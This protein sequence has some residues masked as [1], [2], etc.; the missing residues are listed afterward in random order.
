MGYIDLEEILGDPYLTTL[1]VISAAFAFQC[2]VTACAVAVW[3]WQKWG[4]YGLIVAYGIQAVLMLAAGS[5]LAVGGSIIGL[6]ILVLLVHSRSSMFEKTSYELTLRERGGLLTLF[7]VLIISLSTIALISLFVLFFARLRSIQFSL[8][9]PSMLL[10]IYLPIGVEFVFQCVMILC[11]VA[12][13]H[14]KKW[15]YQSLAAIYAVQIVFAIISGNPIVLFSS[16]IAVGIFLT[17]I[18]RRIEMFE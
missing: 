16:L 6:I 11:A 9:N 4:Y 17:L 15:G 12:V 13:W 3:K 8:S 1:P 2:L 14:W 10:Q 18:N 5:I 7:L